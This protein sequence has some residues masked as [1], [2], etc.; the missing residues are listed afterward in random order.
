MEKQLTKELHLLK[1]KATATESC[2]ERENFSISV[3]NSYLLMRSL[4]RKPLIQM[5]Y[6]VW[7]CQQEFMA[8]F[9]FVKLTITIFFYNSL[10]LDQTVIYF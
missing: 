10:L 9:I 7:D 2:I 1:G 4:K 8:C 3:L 5:K 6:D